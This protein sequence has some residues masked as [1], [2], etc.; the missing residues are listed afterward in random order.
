MD[1]N[2]SVPSFAGSPSAGVI[3]ATTTTMM[4]VT[5]G[6]LIIASAADAADARIDGGLVAI[7][8]GYWTVVKFF[9]AGN[10]DKAERS[11]TPRGYAASG[12]RTVAEKP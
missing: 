11:P 12:C 10:K 1:P 3:V 4:G 7:A 6:L 8:G 2:K 9:R 5:L